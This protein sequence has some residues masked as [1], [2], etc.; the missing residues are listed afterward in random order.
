MKKQNFLTN[1]QKEFMQDL[2]SCESSDGWF[3]KKDVY[4]HFQKLGWQDKSFKSV[5]GSLYKKNVLV[6]EL[7]M[8]FIKEAA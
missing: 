1:K 8:F 2:L 7:E 4:D 6:P 5:L 3:Y